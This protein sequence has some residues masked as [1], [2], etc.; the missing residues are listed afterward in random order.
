[1]ESRSPIRA[2]ALTIYLYSNQQ[3]P[4]VDMIT[5]RTAIVCILMVLASSTSVLHAQTNKTISANKAS[6]GAELVPYITYSEYVEI[7]FN[8]E[9]PF[10]EFLS[11]SNV[12]GITDQ[13]G[14]PRSIEE[15][16]AKGDRYRAVLQY[17]EGTITYDAFP[18]GRT[19]ITAIEIT[20]SEWSLTVGGVALRPGEPVGR[21][22]SVVRNHTMQAKSWDPSGPYRAGVISVAT[23]E[24][25][26]P[27]NVKLLQDGRMDL[28]FTVDTTS[29][30]IHRVRFNRMTPDK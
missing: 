4:F 26:S 22:S 28:S 11:V 5:T 15:Q 1:M 30:K 16:G 25:S 10:K 13:L 8:S 23:P 9:I 21:L 6:S 7:R 29:E 12:D 2:D 17:P 3:Q 18:D 27:A 14:E 19:G 24:T 20:S